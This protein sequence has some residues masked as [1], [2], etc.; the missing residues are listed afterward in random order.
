MWVQKKTISNIDNKT[1][2]KDGLV[3]SSSIYRQKAASKFDEKWG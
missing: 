2:I 1:S 3:H